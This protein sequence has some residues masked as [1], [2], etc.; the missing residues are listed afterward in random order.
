MAM[1][2]GS[3]A[4]LVTLLMATLL[5]APAHGAQTDPRETP[6]KQPLVEGRQIFEAKGCV[7]CHSVRGAASAAQVGPDLGRSGSWRD[8]MQFAGALW[9]HTPAMSA[10]MREQGMARP[11]VTPDEMGKLMSFL[12][13]ARFLDEPGDVARGREV[14]EQRSCAHCHQLGGHGGTVGPRLDELGEYIS[15]SFMAQALWNHG[16][17]MAA[18]MAEQNLVRPNLEADDVANIVAYLRGD[19]RGSTPLDLAYAQAGSPQKGKI[20]FQQKGCVQCHAIGGAGGTVGPDLG[21]QRPRAHVGAMAA[22][23]WNH[24]P[25]MWGKMKEVGRPIPKLSDAEMADLLAYLY[26]V[27]YVGHGG[28]ATRGRELFRE[29][30]CS[31]CHAAG[32]E[33][34]K[35]AAD[36]AASS[37]VRSP[38]HWAAAVWNHPID[39]AAKA[40]EP[41]PPARFE[42]DEMRDLVEFVRAAGGAK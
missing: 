33:A 17:E 34:R 6:P 39:T 14:F 18:K 10:K 35:G 36:L 37:A 28:N 25:A 27:Q 7:G 31:A 26:F 38:F 8:V 19:A 11:A 2:S 13:A 41:P 22:A 42:D 24:G 9:N 12:F 20:V 21:V 16:P 1:T 23:L 3:A 5:V 4:A 15:S 40:G 30:A 32:G 29:K